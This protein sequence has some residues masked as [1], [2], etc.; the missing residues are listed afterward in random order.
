LSKLT[1]MLS[2]SLSHNHKPLATKFPVLATYPQTKSSLSLHPPPTY[3]GGLS[4]LRTSLGY[5]NF[6]SLHHRPSSCREV[7]GNYHLRQIV[8]GISNS[9][10]T[11]DY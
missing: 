3:S 1:P 6:D 11:P 8:E 9:P 7:E 10:Q 4:K 5:N 2:I